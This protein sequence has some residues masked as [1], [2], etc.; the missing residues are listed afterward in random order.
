[1]KTLIVYYSFTRN[2]EILAENLKAR[3]SCNVLK[4]EEVKKR[5][6]FTILLD[7]IFNRNTKLKPHKLSLLDYDNFIFIAPIWAGR[8]ATP[9]KTFLTNHK[10][11]IRRYS[12]ITVCGGVEGQKEK[13]SKQLI[14]LL[15]RSPEKVIE[16][17]VADLL[18]S[19]GKRK[20]TTGYQID[21]NDLVVFEEKIND[22]LQANKVHAYTV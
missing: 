13:I 11:E 22:F 12:F 2:N 20:N 15:N 1:M 21:K 3:L 7:I 19:E 5:T 10:K 4:I 16:L 14:K 8:L 18:V 17:W 9:L 6:G